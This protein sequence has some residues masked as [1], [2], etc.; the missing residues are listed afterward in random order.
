M[1][2]E[3]FGFSKKEKA[4]LPTR[5]NLLHFLQKIIGQCPLFSWSEFDRF[6]RI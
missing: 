3:G 2:K 5:V 6:R 4:G 1:Y